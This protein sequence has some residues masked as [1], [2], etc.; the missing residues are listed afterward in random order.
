[1][2][3][4]TKKKKTK[5]KLHKMYF[6]ILLENNSFFMLRVINESFPQKK[7]LIIYKVHKD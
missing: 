1:M 5:I 2:H 3:K 4:T 7:N 6:S